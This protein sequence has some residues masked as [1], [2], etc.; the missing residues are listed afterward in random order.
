MQTQSWSDQKLHFPPTSHVASQ[1]VVYSRKEE[2]DDS[3]LVLDFLY[4]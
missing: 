1:Q 4:Y 2:V 3:F